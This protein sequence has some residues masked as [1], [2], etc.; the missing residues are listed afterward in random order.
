MDS[1][2]AP[3]EPRADQELEALFE[4]NEGTYAALSVGAVSE[5]G[6]AG[7]RLGPRRVKYSHDAM[8]DLI[9]ASPGIQQ[10]TLAIHFGYTVGWISTIMQSDAFQAKLAARKDE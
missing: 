9:I 3:A 1:N 6:Y 5:P 8:I 10:N 2:Y 4:Q 7:T